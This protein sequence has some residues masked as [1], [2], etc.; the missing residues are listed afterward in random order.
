[1]HNILDLGMEEL[2]AALASLG[3]PAYRARQVWQWIYA[4]GARRF[5]EMSNLPASFRESLDAAY[6]IQRLK[7]REKRVASDGTVKWLLELTDGE[8]IESV[9]IPEED[10]SPASLLPAGGERSPDREPRRTLCLSS[11]VGCAFGCVFCRTGLMGLKRSL[12][13][14][15]I[16]AQVFTAVEDKAAAKTGFEGL[17]LVFMGMGEPTDNWDAVRRAILNLVH[18]EGVGLSPRRIT[19]STVGVVPALEWLSDVKVNVALS[20][21]AVRDDLRSRLMPVDKKYP[22]AELLT[23][24]RRFRE[25]SRARLTFEYVLLRGINDSDQDA[26]ALGEIAG[27]VRARVNIIPFNSSPDLPFERPTDDELARFSYGV[28]QGGVRALVRKSRGR[29]IL[30]ACGQLAVMAE[31][32]HGTME[33]SG[34]QESLK[35]G[36]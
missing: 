9:C 5:E 14:G 20:I 1:M 30:A 13:A 2:T 23:A 26:R 22:L 4:R 33:S 3:Q 7:V 12:T 15:E 32:G 24:A 25:Q 28:T 10:R 18:K 36:G 35:I 29:D 17:N 8:A 19:V 34:Q 6:R 11:Q 16:V 31:S 27:Q 21:N